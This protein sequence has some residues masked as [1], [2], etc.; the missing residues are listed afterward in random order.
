MKKKNDHHLFLG[1]EVVV[2][3]GAHGLGVEARLHVVHDIAQ[4]ARQDAVIHG[5]VV[6]QQRASHHLIDVLRKERAQRKG[7]TICC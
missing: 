4:R 2:V 3:R 1:I 7:I 5:H 6:E